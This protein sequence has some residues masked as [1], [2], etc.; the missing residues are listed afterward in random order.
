MTNMC[1]IDKIVCET[2][3]LEGLNNLAKEHRK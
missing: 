2:Q 1:N 3:D